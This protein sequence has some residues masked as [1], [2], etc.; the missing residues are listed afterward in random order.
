MATKSIHTLVKSNDV[1]RVRELVQGDRCLINKKNIRNQSPIYIAIYKGLYEMTEMLL[2][3]N[4]NLDTKIPPLIIAAKNNDLPMIKLLI[5]Y[6]AKLND[7]YLRDTALMIALRN[8]YLDIAEYLLS[9]GAEFVKYRHKVIYKYLSKDAYK[10]LFRFNCDVNII[11]ENLVTPMYYA[12]KNDDL[13]L[14]EMLLDNNVAIRDD[15]E[16]W[17][18]M[19][20][21]MI[22][23]YVNKDILKRIYNTR[24]LE[25]SNDILLYAVRSS[26][27]LA[28]RFILEQGHY[29][30]PIESVFNRS[31]LFYALKKRN[32]KI[33]EELIKYGAGKH[34]TTLDTKTLPLVIS[35]YDTDMIKKII[36]LIREEI[37]PEYGITL[38]LRAIATNNIN[39]VKLIL[40]LGV[41]VN[42]D[43]CNILPLQSAIFK[44]RTDMVELL[45]DYGADI[46][47][48]NIYGDTPLHTAA[49]SRHTYSVKRLLE[50]GANIN[51][52]NSVGR[53]PISDLCSLS[54]NFA[55]INNGSIDLN[56]CKEE[57]I[58]LSHLVLLAKKDNNIKKDRG[59]KK[60]I[61]VI[62]RSSE[63]CNIVVSC[64]KELHYLKKNNLSN[65]YT[66]YDFI[67][68]RNDNKLARFYKNPILKKLNNLIY[69]KSIATKAVNL[70]NKRYMLLSES[71]DFIS[72]HIM[73]NIPKEVL[74]T[75]CKMLT[76][77]E[78]EKIR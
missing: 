1:G 55:S 38:L 23:F 62:I 74:L 39:I 63:Y 6:G 51:A 18:I 66:L 44:H 10:L 21:C 57:K 29:T 37:D 7:I 50:L 24:V 54:I 36:E 3:N 16:K 78:L 60:T 73:K 53:T 46:H 75:M 17:Y 76:N 33:I 43:R 8:G 77:E 20:K 9:L 15:L 56:K 40:D 5:Q 13:D 69:Y 25:R 42:I 41:A 61:S 72:R 27:L 2:L 64:K 14:L 68:E 67:V 11:D 71:S 49:Y 52:I 48:P 28:V 58:M 30:D 70:S 59:Y 31:P 22:L 19:K 47:M 35:S 32:F 26:N 34:M 45:I 12:A 4:A 65:G